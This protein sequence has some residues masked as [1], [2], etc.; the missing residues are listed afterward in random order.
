MPKITKRAVDAL[1][2]HAGADYFVWDS[3]LRGF[4]VRVRSSGAKT[5]LL[6]YRNDERRTRW[7]HLRERRGEP[8]LFRAHH[9]GPARS[10]A[11]GVT[12]GYIHLD[13]ALVLAAS[14]VS[15]EIALLLEGDRRA[16]TPASRCESLDLAERLIEI[17]S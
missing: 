4:G 16:A 14:R 5:Y 8:E 9:R 12:Q 13:Q 2:P 17:V 11:R 1:I 3:E 15:A 7:A 10:A 6:R